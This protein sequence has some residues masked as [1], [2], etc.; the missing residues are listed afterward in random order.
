MGS[1]NVK[2]LFTF[3]YLEFSLRM[4]MEIAREEAQQVFICM[5]ECG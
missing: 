5:K 2:A 4:A 1:I 3:L